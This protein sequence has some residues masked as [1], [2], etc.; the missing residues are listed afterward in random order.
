MGPPP[1][2]HGPTLCPWAWV[3]FSPCI[4]LL[5]ALAGRT[6]SGCPRLANRK[7]VLFPL[8][9]PTRRGSGGFFSFLPG[10][11][12][13]K[14][15]VPTGR[16]KKPSVPWKCLLLM[17]SLHSPKVPSTAHQSHLLWGGR[18]CE[19]GSNYIEGCL[20]ASLCKQAI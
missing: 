1:L 4:L 6:G 16:G 11:L 18:K 10:I 12:R 14:D 2:A 20:C 7:H 17:S 9:L 3:Q 13:L 5:W 15:S 19:S 8:S